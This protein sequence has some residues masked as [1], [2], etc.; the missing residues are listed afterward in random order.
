MAAHE[1]DM[2]HSMTIS[3][4]AVGPL[5]NQMR[6]CKVVEPNSTREE[7]LPLRTKAL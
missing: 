5:L 4:V 1:T 2:H 3:N 7:K 6:K